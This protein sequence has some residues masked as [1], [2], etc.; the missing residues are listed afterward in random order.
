VFIV[1]VGVREAVDPYVK[2]PYVTLFPAMIICSLV[3]GRA[4]GILAAIVG[5]LIA[6][7]LWLPPRGSFALEWPT[8]YLSA[9]L[10]ILTSTILLL[11]MRGL[12]KRSR[13]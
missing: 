7:Y 8:G 6:W 1:A 12:N 10:Y 5:G 2:I 4:A 11:L 3:G 13:R 9:V